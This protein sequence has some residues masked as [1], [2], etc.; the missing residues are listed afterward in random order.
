MAVKKNVVESEQNTINPSM[1]NVT[2]M[3][4]YYLIILLP[5]AEIVLRSIDAADESEENLVCS[6]NGF[7]PDDFSTAL[8]EKDNMN[9][10]RL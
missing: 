1:G 7:N 2:N 5:K 8:T 6:A 10:G 4:R 9:P 3:Y